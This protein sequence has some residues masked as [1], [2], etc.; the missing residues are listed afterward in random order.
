MESSPSP[1][2]SPVLSLNELTLYFKIFDKQQQGNGNNSNQFKVSTRHLPHRTKLNATLRTITRTVASPYLQ[3]L[4]VFF[5]KPYKPLGPWARGLCPFS[6]LTPSLLSGC[7]SSG[8][9][10]L[11][12]CERRDGNERW[13]VRPV[14][15]Q[16]TRTPTLCLYWGNVTWV[17]THCKTVYVGARISPAGKGGRC[18]ELT[19]LPASCADC[20]ESL[21]VST[22]WSPKGLAWGSFTPRLFYRQNFGL[23][24][25]ISLFDLS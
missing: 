17:V 3:R 6:F 13:V 4:N 10:L 7:R 5:Q 25:R 9:A 16:P 23:T 15:P 11:S 22:P 21:E 24:V 14:A 8:R 19:T 2:T 1:I 20:P 12:S 18:V